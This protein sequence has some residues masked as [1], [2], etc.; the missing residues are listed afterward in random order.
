MRMD[1][2]TGNGIKSLVVVILLAGG[3]GTSGRSESK[4]VSPEV[5]LRNAAAFAEFQD[6]V[7]AYV[8]LHKSMEATLP[9]LK[10][11]DV[12]EMIKAHQLA[13]ARKIREARPN[14]APGD[15]FAG[16]SAE[17]FRAAAREEFRGPEG[18]DARTTIRQ[19]EPLANIDIRLNEA[20]PDGVPFT[21]VPPTL[22]LKFPK[23]P[24]QVAYRIVGRDLILIDVE[25]DLVVDRISELIP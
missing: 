21:T 23:L 5:D 6:R 8:K 16:R 9:S 10:P 11:T 19:G 4:A 15:I 13:L 17:A 12:P 24:D 14:A 2:W 18:H 3:C 1:R 22:L 25:A 20:Y 7:E